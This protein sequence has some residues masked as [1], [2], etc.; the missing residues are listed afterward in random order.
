MPTPGNPDYPSQYLDTASLELESMLYARHAEV[1]SL[2][3]LQLQ[4]GTSIPALFSQFYKFIQNPSSVSVETFKRMVD[5]DDTVGSGMDFLTT[6]LAARIGRYTHKS[7]EITQWVN[8]TLEEID[9]GWVNALKEMLS[10]TW[11]GYSYVIVSLDGSTPEI[12][13]W[14]W[15]GEGFER[16]RVE[17]ADGS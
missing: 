6:C 11:A 7:K 12:G 4:R 5:T 13:S 17:V 10:A 15:T 8:E 2:N 1:E 14:R 3:D 9:G 16:E